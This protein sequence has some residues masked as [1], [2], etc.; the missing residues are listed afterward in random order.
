VVRNVPA[1]V[2]GMGTANAFVYL[3]V[4]LVR[5]NVGLCVLN[6]LPFPPLDGARLL[7]RS[8]DDVQRAIAPYSFLILLVILNVRALRMVFFWPVGFLG[9]ALQAVFGLDV[10][11]A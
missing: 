9:A 1:A 7:P 4:A 3:L 5:V 11:L 2:A 8:L 6:L 10:G